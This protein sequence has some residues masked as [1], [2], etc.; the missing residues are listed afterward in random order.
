MRLA[1]PLL[2][3]LTPNPHRPSL[4]AVVCMVASVPLDPSVTASEGLSSR[5]PLVGSNWRLLMNVGRTKSETAVFGSGRHVGVE[6]RTMPDE[7]AAS[8]ATLPLAVDVAF[9]ENTMQHAGHEEILHPGR[10][11]GAA[12]MA[13]GTLESTASFIGMHGQQEVRING[14]EAHLALVQKRSGT[15]SLRFWLDLEGGVTHHDVELQPSERLFFFSNCWEREMMDE[16]TAKLRQIEEQIE[17]LEARSA[18]VER[19]ATTDAWRRMRSFH[20]QEEIRELRFIAELERKFRRAELPKE[21][22]D[23]VAGP[24]GT[25]VARRGLIC[26]KREWRSS[27]FGFLKVELPIPRTMYESVGTFEL[28]PL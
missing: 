15:H 17:D 26:V 12:N 16:S 28:R 1:V 8:G 21:P 22:Q 13:L 2:A 7:C 5:L 19:A 25:A 20:D 3:T 14:G 10:A 18:E 24:C 11:S 27:P 6:P 4:D 9:G 23:P